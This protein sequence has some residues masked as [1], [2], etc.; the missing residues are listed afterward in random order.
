MAGITHA[1]IEPTTR[2]NFTCGFCAGRAMAQGDLDWNDFTRFLDIHPDL[3]HVELQGEGEPMLHPRFFDMVDACRAR[4]IRVGLI[5][6]GSLLGEERVA[7]LLGAGL[8]SIHVSMESSDPGQFEA[9]RGGRFAKVCEGLVRLIDSRRA[10]GLEQPVIGLAVTVL[11]D[12]LA[13][14]DGICRLYDALGLDGGIVAQPLQTMPAYRRHYRA[15][16][17]A[18]MLPASLMPHFAELRRTLARRAPVRRTE[19]FFYFSLFAGFDGSSCPWLERGAY[20][21][22]DGRVTGCC[23]MKDDALGPLTAPDAV[24]ARRAALRAALNAGEVPDACRGCS[25]AAAVAVRHRP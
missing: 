6:N 14:V 9:I 10:L 22:Q 13:A 24:A 18:Q 2:C 19:D 12:T 20:L 1:Q 4:G 8:T 7:R 5:T 23:F 11:R 15:G 25:T 3:A 21:A 17:A 16:I